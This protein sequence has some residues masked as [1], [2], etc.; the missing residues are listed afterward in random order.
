MAVRNRS[1][2]LLRVPARAREAQL[3][4]SPA[5]SSAKAGLDP[6]TLGVG[7]AVVAAAAVVYVLT[8]ARDIVVGDTAEI[9]IV[10]ATLGVA[11]APGY[12]LLTI[13]GHLFSLLPVGPIPFRV[14][15]LSVVVD[16]AAVGIV[17]L[18][19]Y[20]LSANRYASAAA[21]L[22]LAF[23]P[24][25]WTWSLVAET[26]P[27]NNLLASVLIYLLVVWY[28]QP[29]RIR[30]LVAAAFTAGL[31]MT[32]HQT[33]GLMA[34]G[35]LYL[36][37]RRRDVLLRNPIV[38]P[39][40]AAAVVLGLIPYLYIPWA[41]SQH[42]ALNWRSVASLPDLI[43]LITRADYGS[44][45]LVAGAGKSTGLGQVVALTT[46]FT[47]LEAALLILGAILIYGR[48]RWYFW[49]VMLSVAIT[50]P[51]FAAYANLDISARGALFVLERFF[52]L[53]HV[54]VAPVA[55]FGVLKAADLIREASD[56]KRPIIV[57][58]AK[59]LTPTAL[60]A[61]IAVFV[62]IQSA[63]AYGAIDQSSNHVAHTFAEDL[64]DTME[65]GSILLAKGDEVVLPAAY[66]QI[67]EGYRTDVTLVMLGLL[68]ADWYVRQF[69]ERNPDVVVPFARYNR[70][71]A[72][73]KLLV[74][75]NWGRP[76][77]LYGQIPDNSTEK[78]YWLYRRGLVAR[79]ELMATDIALD[80]M[81]SEYDRLFSHYR[82]PSLSAIK[83]DTF[84]REILVQYALPA[85]RVGDEYEQARLPDQ[86]RPW[87][88]RALAI[89]PELPAARQA[90]VRLTQ[91]PARP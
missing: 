26:F 31:G 21:A 14:N 55:A 46:S 11:H 69:K 40:G 25:F 20:R 90:M 82:P 5:S 47:L 87:Y 6:A 76:I 42:P 50:G 59:R 91:Q 62:F 33:I 36:L 75:A 38:F 1:G 35:I 39:G 53:P 8:A 73:L 58:I 4:E 16:V 85:Y 72:A 23:N 51:A 71:T 68:P 10:A 12:P 15:L 28:E 45:Q 89:D 80:R 22:L 74:D 34:P 79:F 30:L 57:I 17:Y 70:T 65:P 86:A 32:N 54:I 77:S 84:E 66:L 2:R 3:A 13:L 63:L 83:A 18:T 60:S 81:L 9:V 37:W 52:L 41:A 61:A 48:V 7:L 78:D 44:G 19:A 56:G 27:L 67:V 49:F 64:L 24:L 43:A 88:E 29:R